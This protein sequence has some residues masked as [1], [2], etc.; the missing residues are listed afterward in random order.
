MRLHGS[1][2]AV[3]VI[4]ESVAHGCRDTSADRCSEHCPAFVGAFIP[5][6]L[7]SIEIGYFVGAHFRDRRKSSET[8][9]HLTRRSPHLRAVLGRLTDEEGSAAQSHL[10]YVILRPGDLNPDLVGTIERLG[11]GVVDDKAQARAHGNN[12]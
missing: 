6:S 7:R 11:G 8:N 5:R 2:L 3:E 12:C 9:I 4:L 1:Q 10:V